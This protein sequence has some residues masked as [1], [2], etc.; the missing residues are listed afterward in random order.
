M[1]IHNVEQ[2][3]QAWLDAR[4]GLLTASNATAIAANGK[5][6]D[7]YLIEI[8]A[9]ELSTAERDNYTNDQ[10]ERGKELEEHAI[11]MYEL[12]NN[13]T[14]ERVGFIECDGYGASPDGLIGENDLIEVKCPKDTVYTKLLIDKK[15]DSGYVWQ[16]QMQLLVTNRQRGV[17][18]YYNPNFKKSFCTFEIERDEVAIEKLKVGIETGKE[19][20]AELKAKL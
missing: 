10:I 16:I 1:K 4:K 12:E 20:L 3:S 13:L 18:V 11:A 14:V 5:G 19:R 15:P 9:E 7:T 17:L 2:N 8:L 6:L